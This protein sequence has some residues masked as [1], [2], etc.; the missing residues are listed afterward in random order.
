[1]NENQQL[2]GKEEVY[3][4]ICNS[5]LKLEVAK[6]HLKWTVSDVARDSEITRSLV[7][8]YFGKE[9]ISILEEATRFTLELIFNT[10]G[11][12]KMGVKE[13]IKATLKKI[14]TMPYLF[15]FY[16][17]SKA[18]NGKIAKLIREAESKLLNN[19][20][21]DYPNY[22]KDEVLKIYLLELGSISY[23]LNHEK[24]DDIFSKYD[25]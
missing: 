9:K 24:S 20:A 13:R 6:G 3:Y 12:N 8:Y 22:S 18:E 7:Y 19:L 21:N 14:N 5:V 17:I 1:M 2:S 16:F 10:E 15:V 4:K 25:A 11:K 23:Q